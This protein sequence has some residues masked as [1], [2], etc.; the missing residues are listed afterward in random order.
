M[1]VQ[2]LSD[3]CEQENWNPDEVVQNARAQPRLIKRH[4]ENWFD[5]MLTFQD[6]D[7]AIGKINTV[8]G[9][10]GRND[11]ER[12][13][14]GYKIPQ[15]KG[16]KEKEYPFCPTRDQ[17]LKAYNLD[18]WKVKELG[19]DMQLFLLAESQSGLSEVDLLTL[20]TKDDSAVR[21]AGF[22][23]YE[24]IEKRACQGQESLIGCHQKDKRATCFA[25]NVLWLRGHRATGPQKSKVIQVPRRRAKLAQIF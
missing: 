21:W 1:Y 15:R 6:R 3:F 18:V 17:L 10:L 19:K 23:D 25:S 12:E 20:D 7:T 8:L 22:K 2:R 4:L 11:V 13:S 16:K 5:Y 14:I 9:F 24:C